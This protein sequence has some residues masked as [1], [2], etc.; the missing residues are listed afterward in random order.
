MNPLVLVA[1]GL[2]GLAAALSLA[3]ERVRPERVLLVGDSHSEAPWTFG[4][5]VVAKLE[6]AGIPLVVRKGHRGKGVGWYNTSGTLRD[7]VASVRPDLLIVALGGNDAG[8]FQ[9]ADYAAALREFVDTAKAGGIKHIIWFGPPRSDKG[10]AYKQPARQKVANWQA[11]HLPG[12]GVQWHDSMRLT[13]DL[14]TRDGVHYEHGEYEVWA[15]R[16]VAGP[17]QRAVA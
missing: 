8:R 11:K 14:P 7:E 4:G 13:E 2:V 17:L 12:M 10:L 1:L 16:A 3:S 5:R 15:S 6:E 9:E